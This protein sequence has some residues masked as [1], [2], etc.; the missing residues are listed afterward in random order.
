LSSDRG[1]EVGYQTRALT[2]ALSILDAF[3]GDSEALSLATLH[4]S[5]GLPKS[6]IIRLATVLEQY[7][8]IRRR[9][10]GYE[11]GPKNLELGA[12][13]LRR[14]GVLDIVRPVLETLRDELGETICLASLSGPDVLHLDVV[15][16]LRPIHYRTDVGSRAPAHSTALGKA[17]LST[18]DEHQVDEVLGAPPYRVLTPNTLVERAAL[19]TELEASRA[20]DYSVDDEESS[21]GLKCVGIA[22]EAPLLGTI[23][24]SASSSPLSITDSAIPHVAAALVQARND[25]VSA[26]ERATG[27]SA[28]GVPVDA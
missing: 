16:S 26:L 5:L 6:T 13:Y 4:Q 18:M 3:D 8:Y 15:P 12:L 14:H 10:D 17:I 2:R 9:D 25:V 23:A 28:S 24:I 27:L 22:A 7:G 19:L 11:L 21:L 1:P 20:R